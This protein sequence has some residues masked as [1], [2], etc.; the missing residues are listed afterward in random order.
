MNGRSV[1]KELHNNEGGKYN[2]WV[3][4]DFKETDKYGNFKLKKYNDNYGFDLGKALE[5]H[6]I[7]ELLD[8]KQKGRLLESLERGNRQTVTFKVQDKEH[9]LSIE[10]VPQFKSLN[11]YDDRQKKLNVQQLLNPNEEKKTLKQK[12]K[13]KQRQGQHL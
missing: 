7:K 5:Q 9:K 8:P 11:F 4:L 12:T 13:Q 6:P 3:Q 10:A 2:A 1:Y